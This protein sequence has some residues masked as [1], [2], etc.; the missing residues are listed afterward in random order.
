MEIRE[1]HIRY[2]EYSTAEQLPH[3]YNILMEAAINATAS[4]YA[5]YSKFNVG[6]A[7]LMEGG[8]VV[9]GSNQENAASPSG[10]CA[11]RVA[12]FAAH[13]QYPSEAVEAIAIVAKQNGEITESLT[14]PCSACVQ[15]M[16]ESQKR[17][18][19]PMKIVVGSAEKVQIIA[20][21]DDLAPFSFGK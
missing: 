8:S 14:Y 9:T 18:G 21:A 20:S 1:R 3:P 11:E 6:A 17:S 16:I 12:L 7:V 15:V 13:H 10:L 19:K 2:E 4:S 5:P